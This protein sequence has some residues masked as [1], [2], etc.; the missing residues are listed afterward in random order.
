MADQK[1]TDLNEY[2]WQC[3]SGISF[4]GSEP[5][6]PHLLTAIGGFFEGK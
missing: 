5:R 1:A 6:T 3:H 2:I 4:Q